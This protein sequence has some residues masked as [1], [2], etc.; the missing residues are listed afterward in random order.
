MNQEDTKNILCEPRGS[1]VRKADESQQSMLNNYYRNS[2]TQCRPSAATKSE[3]RF[4]VSGFGVCRHLRP[5]TY[6]PIPE[7]SSGFTLTKH[8][9]I[10]WRSYDLRL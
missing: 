5:E 4:R 1:A 9:R 10:L 6:Y 3:F 2:N 8:L 7:E